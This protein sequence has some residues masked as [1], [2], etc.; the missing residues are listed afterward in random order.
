MLFSVEYKRL[1]TYSLDSYA[2]N[3]NQLIMSAGYTF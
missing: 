2:N 3:A 1:Q